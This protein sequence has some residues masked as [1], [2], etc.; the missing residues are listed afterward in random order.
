MCLYARRVD[1]GIP[2]GCRAWGEYVHGG[3]PVPE[4]QRRALQIFQAQLDHGS[5]LQATWQPRELNM[6]A[7]FL[8][9]RLSR[10]NTPIGCCHTPSAGSMSDGGSTQSTASHTPQ[11]ASPWHTPSRAN[12]APS[13]FNRTWHGRILRSVGGDGDYWLFPPRPGHSS[14]D[15]PLAHVP[16]RTRA[17]GTVIAPFAAWAPWLASLRQG[18]RW[19]AGVTGLV[20]LEL[21]QACIS[22]PCDC[23][24]LVN[25]CE[26]LARRPDGRALSL[27]EDAA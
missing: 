8:S 23:R 7:Y 1:P 26:L 24:A 14:H 21:P 22:V 15:P 16:R 27:A 5:Q 19:T 6:R 17:E 18:R 12:S 10:P 4:I 3:S 9:R 2:Q 20:L 11:L 25:G 13:I